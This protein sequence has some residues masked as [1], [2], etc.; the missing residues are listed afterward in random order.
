MAMVANNPMIT[1]TMSSSIRVKPFRDITAVPQGAGNADHRD[2]DQVRSRTLEGG[3]GG[4]P[5]AKR[6]NVVVAVFELRYVAPP[7]EQCLDISLLARLGHRAIE[8]GPDP[9]EAGE[10][11]LDESLRVILGDAELAGESERPLPVDRGEVDR[12]G[13]GSHVRGDLVLRHVEDHRGRL[14]MN[15][16]ALLEGFDERRVA[17]EM[18]QEAQ[19]DLGIVGR[20]EHGAG[21]SDEGAANG[22]AA[23]GTHGDVLQV[24]VGGG[25]PSRGGPGLI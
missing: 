18:G 19:L 6:A 7:S 16:P 2:L 10:V 21:R 4:G 3:V 15:V 13:A 22:L 5:L 14:A 8:P 1:T 17:R 11:L 24:R 9:G 20:E 25:E 23:R 12:L